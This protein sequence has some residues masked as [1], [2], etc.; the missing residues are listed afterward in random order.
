MADVRLALSD[1]ATP[2]RLPAL[3][4]QCGK[5]APTIRRMKM[6]MAGFSKNPDGCGPFGCLLVALDLIG[7]MTAKYV[8][9][10]APLCRYHRWI[11]PPSF[12]VEAI[13]AEAIELSG[14]SE[15]FV[16]A[17]KR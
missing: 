2:G 14:V 12:Q 1:A 5:E 3:C 9:L 4:M 10:C 8:P 6:S 16:K 15:E 13:T 17:L 7:W 11:V